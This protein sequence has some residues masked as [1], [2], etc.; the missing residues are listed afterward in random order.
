[1]NIR[2]H[3]LPD[4][5]DHIAVLLGQTPGLVLVSRRG[6]YLD[7]PPSVLVRVYLEVRLGADHATDQAGTSSPPA[8]DRTS[9]GGRRRR[10]GRR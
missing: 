10:G 6:P 8:A 9:A 3:A 4:E 5:C 7:R 1:V 2:L